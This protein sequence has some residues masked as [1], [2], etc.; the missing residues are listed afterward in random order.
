M[1]SMPPPH[2]RNS[3]RSGTT[4]AMSSSGPLKTIFTLLAC[5]L[6]ICNL[7]FSINNNTTTNG[8]EETIPYNPPDIQQQSVAISQPPSSPSSS[9]LHNRTFTIGICAIIK[10][11]DAYLNE[12][13]DYHL[14]AMNIEQIYLYDHSAEYYLKSWYENTRTH[15]IYKRVHVIH[16]GGPGL[17]Q[18]NQAQQKAFTD[19]VFR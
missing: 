8:D 3:H 14:V 11:M 7:W 6:L 2:S 16:W 10:D 4:M 18:D 9:P 13:L 19:C 17:S 12:W 15:P 5:A 1:L